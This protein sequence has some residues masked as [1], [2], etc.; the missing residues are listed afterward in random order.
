[1]HLLTGA[2][3]TPPSCTL[4]QMRSMSWRRCRHKVGPRH[5]QPMPASYLCTQCVAGLQMTHGP[6]HWATSGP[7]ARRAGSA[8]RRGPAPHPAQSACRCPAP[9]ARRRPAP[10]CQGTQRRL[11]QG[12]GPAA[13]GCVGNTAPLMTRSWAHHTSTAGTLSWCTS[14]RFQPCVTVLGSGRTHLLY[15]RNSPALSSDSATRRSPP[16][17]SCK[18]TKAGINLAMW[19]TSQMRGMMV[20]LQQV[21]CRLHLH[22]QWTVSM[23]WRSHYVAVPAPP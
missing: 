12:W 4:G 23:V 5:A 20:H 18:C 3:V 13:R 15:H 11:N 9:A 14:G 7:G 21:V 2:R 6:H 16:C 22:H 1:M 17:S 8:G 10:C 19:A